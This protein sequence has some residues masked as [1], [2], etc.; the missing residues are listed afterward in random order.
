MG[1]V[2]IPTAGTWTRT[3]P[4]LG[5]VTRKINT[6]ET[7]TDG[8]CETKANDRTPG[9]TASAFTGPAGTSPETHL[10]RLHTRVL[11]CPRGIED[12]QG[13]TPSPTLTLTHPRRP[14]DGSLLSLHLPARTS[15]PQDVHVARKG[16][17]PPAD[18]V[19]SS[20]DRVS[21]GGRGT[22]PHGSKSSPGDDV[23]RRPCL[24]H[25]FRDVGKRVSWHG[26]QSG[27]RPRNRTS[28]FKELP[29]RCLCRD[30]RGVCFLLFICS[31]VPFVS[32]GTRVVPC[33]QQTHRRG[34]GGLCNEPCRCLVTASLPSK[35]ISE[36]ARLQSQRWCLHGRLQASARE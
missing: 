1:R 28:Q 5:A 35:C 24:A 9:P 19:R 32:S 13:D 8:G 25:P 15:T 23:H 21:P 17:Q 10:T 4:H 2:D 22:C 20:T 6:Q 16:Q 34:P 31:G 26:H 30:S 11:T 7:E 14:R 27:R 18:D 29:R 3:S 33:V 12:A 36:P